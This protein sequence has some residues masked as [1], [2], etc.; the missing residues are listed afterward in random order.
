M[1][2]PP[3][4]GTIALPKRASKRAGQQHGSA[5]ELAQLV[6]E[7]RLRDIRRA[8]AH[9]VRAD[10]LDLG[11]EVDEK[12]D[13]REDVEDARHVVQDDLVLGEEA[14]SE[15]RQRTVLVSRGANAAVERARTL[16]HER[17]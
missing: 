9:V 15:D 16:D 13:H 14:R 3:G 10:P 5:D 7:L 2:S 4:G 11:A 6:V 12:V 1:T 17:I 8:D